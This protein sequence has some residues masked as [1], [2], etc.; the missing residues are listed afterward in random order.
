MRLAQHPLMAIDG[1]EELRRRLAECA[2]ALRD[3]GAR[4]WPG[5]SH[6]LLLELDDLGSC[7]GDARI[8]CPVCV[9]HAA[10]HVLR[11]AE[12]GSLPLLDL[13]GEAGTV[14]E[15]CSCCGISAPEF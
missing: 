8:V 4:F 1:S 14:A 11:H 10:A 9:P 15:R 12:L 3:R 2:R 13:V 5:A 6:F 7:T